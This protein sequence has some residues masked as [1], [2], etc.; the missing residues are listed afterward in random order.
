MVCGLWFVTLL[1]RGEATNN[2]FMVY[3]SSITAD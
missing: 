2:E 3:G 1:L